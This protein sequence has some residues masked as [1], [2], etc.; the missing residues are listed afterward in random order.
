[1]GRMISRHPPRFRYVPMNLDLNW[2]RPPRSRN[3]VWTTSWAQCFGI[4]GVIQCP[5]KAA[6]QMSNLGKAGGP[7]QATTRRSHQVRPPRDGRP[8][9]SHHEGAH[10]DQGLGS[11]GVGSL[12]HEAT[13]SD[14]AIGSSWVG[15]GRHEAAE[16]G[17]ESGGGA[18]S[19][20]AP[21]QRKESFRRKLLLSA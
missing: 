15:S 3:S 17:G 10:P 12:R 9:S 4:P 20:G 18:G 14:Q 19:G 21:S 8:R 16:P 1:M 5:V 2:S 13:G 11:S 7:D 6:P